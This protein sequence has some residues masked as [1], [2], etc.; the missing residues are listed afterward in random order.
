MGDSAFKVEAYKIGKDTFKVKR[1]GTINQ[2]STD[3]GLTSNQQ[4]L[5]QL[6]LLTWCAALKKY[7]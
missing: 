6:L 2:F 4:C 7:L 3:T 1:E 5:L